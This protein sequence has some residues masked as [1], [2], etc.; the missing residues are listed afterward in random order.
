MSAIVGGRMAFLSN[1]TVQIILVII[2][3]LCFILFKIKTAK[4]KEK[5][6]V[7]PNSENT[8]GTELSGGSDG[9]A[10][11]GGYDPELLE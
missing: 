2:I 3:I 6:E 8:D 5:F 7:M 10:S 11:D 1:H 9:S 4:I